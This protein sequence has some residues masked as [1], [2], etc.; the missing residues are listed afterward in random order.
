MSGIQVYVKHSEY[1]TLAFYR[2][3]VS[4]S[5]GLC[6]LGRPDSN[7]AVISDEEKESLCLQLYAFPVHRGRT[8]SDNIALLAKVYPQNNLLNVGN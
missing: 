2:A 6:L 1:Y 4:K 5:Y 7:E 8:I 3:E